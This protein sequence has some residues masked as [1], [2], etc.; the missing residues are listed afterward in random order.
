MQVV[1]H[2]RGV[3]TV[4]DEVE[5][6]HSLPPAPPA[7]GPLHLP[8]GRAL[9]HPG[10][11]RL[12]DRVGLVPEQAG[13]FGV[14]GEGDVV[15]DRGLRLGAESLHLLHPAVAAGLL[16]CVERI[17]PQLI[18]EQL[19]LL[20]AKPGHTHQLEHDGRHLSLELREQGQLA[21]VEQGLDLAREVGADALEIG[22]GSSRI[23]P[24]RR[25]RLHHAA[26][27]PGGVAVGPHAKHVAPLKLQEVGDV[28]E[29]G[30][31]V[32]IRHKEKLA[33]SSS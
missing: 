3:G 19:H 26:D 1:H 28:V 32:G 17:D 15:E 10:E 9:P 30:G 18:D 6:A 31:D 20:G 14:L 4:D 8:H 27:H 5:V 22:E 11:E 33:C 16:Q 25:Q 12:H 2:G 24:H 7:T 29:D 23:G 13:M 21:S